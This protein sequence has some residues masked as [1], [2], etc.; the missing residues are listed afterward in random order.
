MSAAAAVRWLGYRKDPFDKV[1]VVPLERVGAER[2]LRACLVVQ[3]L[4]DP[5]VLRRKSCCEDHV[6]WGGAIN[7]TVTPEGLF[8]FVKA[9]C[10]S[11]SYY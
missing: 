6:N 5:V 8:T 9:V 10:C 11:L 4:L 3:P 7:E 2:A 1:P